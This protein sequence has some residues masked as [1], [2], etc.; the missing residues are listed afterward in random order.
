MLASDILPPR[1]VSSRGM[2]RMLDRLET[3]SPGNY[4]FKL[5]PHPPSF[6][7][8][9]RGT[10]SAAEQGGQGEERGAAQ[11]QPITKINV[12]PRFRLPLAPQI[13]FELP[14][15]IGILIHQ[16]SRHTLRTPTSHRTPI[17]HQIRDR[18]HRPRNP[19]PVHRPTP[20]RRHHPHPLRLRSH[21]HRPRRDHHRQARPTPAGSPTDTAPA[22]NPPTASNAPE[23]NGPANSST[24]PHA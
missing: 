18:N 9:K 8:S 7:R 3:D 22:D 6:L 20:P 11:S 4:I 14:H 2:K 13:R 21:R 24:N 5:L 10:R 16:N 19:P 17:P 12:N 15:R 1:T 23:K